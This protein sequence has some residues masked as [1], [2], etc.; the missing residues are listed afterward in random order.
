M[1]LRIK[2]IAKEK[3]ILLKDIAAKIGTTEVVFSRTLNNGNPTLC[4]LIE[5]ASA[6]NVEVWELFTESTDKSEFM[7]L[8]RDK[9]DF[10]SAAT[11][12]E[13]AEIVE[14]LRKEKEE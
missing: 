7:A 2:E 14:K 12:N 3:N 13:L 11:L 10:Y 4:R 8:V 9:N 5:I 6:L 1:A